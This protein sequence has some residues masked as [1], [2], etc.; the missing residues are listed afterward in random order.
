MT[1]LRSANFDF[2]PHDDIALRKRKADE[3]PQQPF[4]SKR[5]RT[6]C[7]ITAPLDPS[8]SE[9]I[10]PLFRSRGWQYDPKRKE[11]CKDQQ[12]L[13]CIYT[14]PFI[15]SNPIWT[16][17]LREIRQLEQHESTPKKTALI[18]FLVAE[19][20]DRTILTQQLYDRIEF[21]A[22]V[23][24][25]ST[26]N[27]CDG[28]IFPNQSVQYTNGS[29]ESQAPQ[30]VQMGNGGNHRSHNMRDSNKGTYHLTFMHHPLHLFSIH[31]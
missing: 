25:Q 15:L 23:E 19:I 16:D 6:D 26:T 5:N 21:Q 1:S 27:E 18:N 9:F 14:V 7:N 28:A 10:L 20:A 17:A 8:F 3:L 13:D 11:L 12:R 2:D 4:T 29:N 22:F 31:S 30:D 24:A